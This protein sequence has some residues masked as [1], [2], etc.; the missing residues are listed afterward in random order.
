MSSIPQNQLKKRLKRVLKVLLVLYVMIGASLYFL[1]EKLL[2][3]PSELPQDYQYEFKY[4]FEEIFLTPEADVSI[5]AIHFKTENPKGAILY[6]HG[7]AGDLSR[8]GT[9]SE[10]FVAKGYDVFIMDYRT[11]G[12]SKGKL[13]EQAFYDDAQFCYGYLLKSYPEEHIT[14]YGRS[15]GTGIATFLASNNKPK[16]LI[17]ETPYYSILDVAKQRFPIFPVSLLLKYKFPSNEFIVDVKCP[18]TMFH[19]TDDGIVPYSSAEK[20]KAVAPKEN[21]TFITIEGGSHNNLIDFDTYRKEVEQL[22]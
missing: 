18:I 14:L 12:K 4:P 15:L 8:W 19:G 1:Q 13:S 21:T 17:L 16:Q 5:N 3:L 7:N 2:F 6:F 11:Y 20:L 9:I 10:F 22:L